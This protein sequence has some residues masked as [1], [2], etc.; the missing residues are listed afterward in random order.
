MT[1]TAKLIPHQNFQVYV[2]TIIYDENIIKTKKNGEKTNYK[3]SNLELI[4]NT[5][6]R[7]MW[8]SLADIEK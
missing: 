3:N 6:M 2:Y 8:C 1:K 4:Q 5:V 7:S